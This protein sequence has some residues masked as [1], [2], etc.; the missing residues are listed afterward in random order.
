MTMFMPG[1][2]QGLHVLVAV[3]AGRV[4]FVDDSVVLAHEAVGDRLLQPGVRGVV[5]RLV[6]QASDV[7]RH[8]DL[9]IRVAF[10]GAT[11]R[12]RTAGPARLAAV[13]IPAARCSDDGKYSDEDQDL[14][15]P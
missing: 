5:E 1:V 8:P 2:G 15:S 11:A 6:A 10:G 4:G 14:R 12:R 3:R 7:E 13:V 9:H